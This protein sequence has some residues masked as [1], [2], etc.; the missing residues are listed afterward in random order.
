MP[1]YA[2]HGQVV[3]AT[4]CPGVGEP[5]RGAWPMDQ[6]FLFLDIDRATVQ[7]QMDEAAQLY[8]HAMMGAR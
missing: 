7:R 6:R 2:H 5:V 1:Q 3:Q 4:Q 8:L